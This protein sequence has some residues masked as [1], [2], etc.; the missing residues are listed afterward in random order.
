M[1]P[2]TTSE[3]A[4]ELISGNPA[5]L[6]R[7]FVTC[8]RTSVQQ[9]R[10]QP[11][12]RALNAT[13]ADPNGAPAAARRAGRPGYVALRM[14]GVLK[15]LPVLHDDQEILLRIFDQRDVGDG[16]AVDD[17]KI[18]EGALLENAELPGIGVARPGQ[19]QQFAIGRGSHLQDFGVF[20]P[21]LKVR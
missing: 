19:R 5:S 1:T 20:V 18:G 9:R 12:R 15:D 4:S 7:A 6:G 17:E 10:G 13:R 16:I 21:A 8:P 2:V 3:M 14:E 11:E